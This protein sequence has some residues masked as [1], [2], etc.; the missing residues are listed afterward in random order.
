MIR[1]ISLA[2]AALF[3]AAAVP[4]MAQAEPDADAL[5]AARELLRAT[6][7]DTQLEQSAQLTAQSMFTTMI[8]ALEEEHGQDFPDDLEAELRQLLV[9]HTENFLVDLR[10]TALED[11]AR[12]Y[13]RYFTADEL[14]ELLRLQTHPVMVR[15]QSIAPQFTAELAQIGLAAE[16]P[17]LAELQRRFNETIEAWQVRQTRHTETP[18]T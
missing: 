16:L 9:E 1:T 14:R 11:S 5:A 7:F 12:I 6:D 2:L 10:R 15:F 17:H 4:A 3:F 18:R 13:A 8:A